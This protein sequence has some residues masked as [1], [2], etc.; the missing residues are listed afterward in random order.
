[1]GASADTDWYRR[2]CRKAR[3]SAPWP[4]MECP[5]RPLRATSSGKLAASKGGNSRVRYSSMRKR[6]DQGAWL[7][8][9]GFLGAGQPSQE[10]QQGAGA[11]LGLR[12][13][14]QG[15][16]HVAAACLRPMPVNT[17][18]AAMAALFA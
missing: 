18:D 12:R 8:R 15:K 9:G 1:M 11:H 4:P 13:Q 16:A 6:A 3:V 7:D 14:E 5:H 17:L 10:I 2:G